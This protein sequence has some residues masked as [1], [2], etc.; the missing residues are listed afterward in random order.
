MSNRNTRS[1]KSGKQPA[2]PRPLSPTLSESGPAP[3]NDSPPFSFPA[4]PAHA[5]SSW[6]P[7]TSNKDKAKLMKQ[8]AALY[9]HTEKI[10]D[11]LVAASIENQR[12][13]GVAFDEALVSSS[14]A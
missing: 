4:R 2:A 12:S 9:D 11:A 6:A 5:S 8:Y 10:K 13:P 14:P 7:P 1:S 3:F